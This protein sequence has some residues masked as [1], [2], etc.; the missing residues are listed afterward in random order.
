MSSQTSFQSFYSDYE[1]MMPEVKVKG[2]LCCNEG[3]N[4]CAKISDNVISY[5][6]NITGIIPDDTDPYVEHKKH[7]QVN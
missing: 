3:I 5:G 4:T 1:G 6:R 7:C 2:K